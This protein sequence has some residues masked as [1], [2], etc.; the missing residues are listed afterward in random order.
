M[1]PF[2]NED[3]LPKGSILNPIALKMAKTLWRFGHSEYNRDKGKNL[4][5]T[6]LARIE[7]GDRNKYDRV[8]AFESVPIQF[9]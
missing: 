2:L 3:A 8:A 9:N 5:L 6:E 4:F 7:K 1:F